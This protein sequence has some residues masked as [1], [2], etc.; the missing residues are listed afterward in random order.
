MH[1]YIFRNKNLLFKSK[2]HGEDDEQERNDMVPT[3][4][5]GL[6]HCDNDNGKHGQWN[7]FL[8]DFQLDKIEWT[9]VLHSTDA[10]GGDHEGILE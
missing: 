5:F 2:K 7:G 9:S 1:F 3:E 6:E 8:N 4:G 10:V